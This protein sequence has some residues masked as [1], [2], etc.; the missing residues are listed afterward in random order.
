MS[1]KEENEKKDDGNSL[2]VKVKITKT[3]EQEKLEEDVEAFKRDMTAIVEKKTGESWRNKSYSEIKNKLIELQEQE[4]RQKFGTPTG[5]GGSGKAP[6]TSID[7]GENVE[8]KEYSSYKEMLEDVKKRMESDD[9]AI[10]KEA[11]IVMERLREKLYLEGEGFDV[12]FERGFGVNEF[13]KKIEKEQKKKRK[14]GD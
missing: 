10:R 11:E 8:V 14:K 2:K 9:E 7:S 13:W 12:K 4:K 1:E 5:G 3:P 6:L